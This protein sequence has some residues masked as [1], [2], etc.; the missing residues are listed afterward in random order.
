M[1]DCEYS[2]RNFSLNFVINDSSVADA[3][4]R[5]LQLTVNSTN[6]SIDSVVLLRQTVGT[7]VP[8]SLT[9][10]IRIKFEILIKILLNYYVECDLQKDILSGAF[11]VFVSY[12]TP[13]VTR[14]FD[15]F[16]YSEKL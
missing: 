15:L 5:F 13:R 9:R 6:N 7:L 10:V 1:R 2:P 11:S 4:R 12:L 3:L 16:E 14:T 8:C